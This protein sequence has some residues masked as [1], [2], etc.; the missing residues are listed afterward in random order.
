MYKN[1][2]SKALKGSWD[3]IKFLQGVFDVTLTDKFYC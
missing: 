3:S 1:W 2:L